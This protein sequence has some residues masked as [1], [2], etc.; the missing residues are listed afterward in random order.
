MP[1]IQFKIEKKE[2]FFLLIGTLIILAWFLAI[3]DRLAP[4][5]RQINPFF[6]MLI[7]QSGLFIGI[8]FVA[9]ILSKRKTQIKASFISFLILLGLDLIYPPYLVSKEGV[10]NMATEYW[11][12]STDA[13]FASLYHY[14][15]SPHML[16]TLTYII[17]P[18]LLILVIPV[19]IANPKLIS[20]ALH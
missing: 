11:Y 14:V 17:T 9:Q 3:S 15:F 2:I 4:F 12:V 8:V 19:I 16:F 7:F 6:A 1:R 10:I 5:L 18:I 13:G 20:R